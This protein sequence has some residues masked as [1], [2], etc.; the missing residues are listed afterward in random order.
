MDNQQQLHKNQFKTSKKPP[1][2][3]NIPHVQKVN[4]PKQDSTVYSY[5]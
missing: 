2:T 3:I 4:T 1:E 5:S